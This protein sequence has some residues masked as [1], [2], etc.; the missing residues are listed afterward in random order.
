MNKLLAVLVSLAAPA[1]SLAALGE[2]PSKIEIFVTGQY[3]TIFACKSSPSGQCYNVL[4]RADGAIL[5]RF[6]LRV[7]ERRSFVDLPIDATVC[8]MD[9]RTEDTQGCARQRVHAL[10]Q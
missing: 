5:D 9:G 6:A 3:R 4:Y 2:D 1:V 7:G 10:A 8:L